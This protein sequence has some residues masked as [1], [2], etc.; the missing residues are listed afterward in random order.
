MHAVAGTGWGAYQS[1]LE[2]NSHIGWTETYG[3]LLPR[4]ADLALLAAG[5]WQTQGGVEPKQALPV[6][7]R[8]NVAKKIAEQL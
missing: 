6:Y 2:Q 4:A 5:Q 7:L 3:D 8:N 1:I